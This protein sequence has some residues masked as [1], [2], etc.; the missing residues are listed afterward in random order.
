MPI[1]RES[2]HFGKLVSLGGIVD[3]TGRGRICDIRPQACGMTSVQI[4]QDNPRRIS[5]LIT[6]GDLYYAWV[7]LGDTAAPDS[8]TLLLQGGSYQIDENNPWTGAVTIYV[9]TGTDTI[10]VTETSL[11]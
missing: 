7:C 9:N 5:A 3:E 10:C 1:V 8:G 2:G 11:P 6:N 4:L